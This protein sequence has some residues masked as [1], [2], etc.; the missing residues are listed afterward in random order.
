MSV[1]EAKPKTKHPLWKA[2]P[3][4]QRIWIT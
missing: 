1:F 2:V 3:W 4:H